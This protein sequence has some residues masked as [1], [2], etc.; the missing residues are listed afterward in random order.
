MY[1]RAFVLCPYRD[2]VIYDGPVPEDKSVTCIGPFPDLEEG[3][4]FI[5]YYY[6]KEGRDT[7]DAGTLSPFSFGKPWRAPNDTLKISK[8]E[9]DLNKLI[10]NL[11]TL[12]KK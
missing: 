12:S 2:I 3:A 5:E 10:P 11:P 7:P 9:N 1:K 8:G 4:F 6:P